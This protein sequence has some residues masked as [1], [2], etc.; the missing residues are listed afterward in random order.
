[1]FDVET[2]LHYELLH[3]DLE[4]EVVDQ[5]DFPGKLTAGTVRRTA[6]LLIECELRG[7][8]EH[9]RQR[10][11]DIPLGSIRKAPPLRGRVPF[12]DVELHGAFP[13]G[14]NVSG[15]REL[16][17][18]AECNRI[19]VTYRAKRG[20][21]WVVDWICNAQCPAG[22]YP[23]RTHKKFSKTLIRQRDDGPEENIALDFP[24]GLFGGFSSD[25]ILLSV[26][27]GGRTVQVRVGT[28]GLKDDRLHRGYVEYSVPDVS[29]EERELVLT[30]LG[31]TYG[32][33]LVR[34][35]T[36]VFDETWQVI[37]Q[38]SCR[39]NMVGSPSDF[40]NASV[41]PTDLGTT[42]V[43]EET[44]QQIVQSYVRVCESG[45]DLEYP[46][47]L[48]WVGRHAHVDTSAATFGSS[49]EA[50][51]RT[52]LNK[53]GKSSTK[54]LHKSVASTLVDALK[55]TLRQ[56]AEELSRDTVSDEVLQILNNKLD[57]LNERSSSMQYPDFFE[58]IR[59]PIGERENEALRERNRPAHG[60][61]YPK[62]DYERLI[63]VENVFRTLLNRVILRLCEVEIPYIDYG[64]L[65]HPLRLLD[66]PSGQEQ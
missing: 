61:R 53:A 1:M 16:T 29:D 43:E 17:V 36:T 51:R 28:V 63:R 6:G 42:F 40:R 10:D 21:A 55:D 2:A 13:W 41:P 11:A 34:L 52:F 47:W 14:E 49:L 24:P 64:T 22:M 27:L 9:P 18:P 56:K 65:G 19:V 54:L 50:L 37:Q 44:V 31:F 23:R 20:P 25:H 3:T 33:Q 45:L 59:L 30:A 38:E 66:D 62:E 46:T 60:H 7:K 57:S 35:G 8:L 39:P 5:T 15:D 4:F 58:R 12:G 48:S 26:E 32:R